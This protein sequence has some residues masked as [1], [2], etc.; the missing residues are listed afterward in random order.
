MLEGLNS[1]FN[2]VLLLG[3]G[4]G[5]GFEGCIRRW[6]EILLMFIFGETLRKLL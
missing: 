1:I 6:A 5:S 3:A 4:R 2:S